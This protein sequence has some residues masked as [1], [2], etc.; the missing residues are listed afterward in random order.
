M[1]NRESHLSDGELVKAL[2]G[3]L[4]AKELQRVEAHLEAC[5]TCRARKG[6]MEHAIAD[7]VHLHETRTELRLPAADG[8]RA[9]LKARLA[10][11][12]RPERSGWWRVPPFQTRRW[13]VGTAC[14]LMLAF[15]GL[16]LFLTEWRTPS[17]VLAAP[18][19]ALTPGAA[20]L[21]NPNRLC[22]E[23]RPRNKD[24]STAVRRRV[25]EEYGLRHAASQA[26][27]VDY[28]ISPALGGAD[29]IHNL[30]P[31]PYTNTEW[32]AKVKDALEDRLRDLVCEGKVELATAQHDIATNWI[33]AYKKYF[34]TDRPVASEE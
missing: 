2:D 21:E 34:Q 33:E 5:W 18:N 20:I 15:L 19:P 31:Q 11:L 29:D 8:P 1:R 30:W 17:V 27:E 25:F 24:V 28:L 32:N 22:Q 4:R 13:I 10:E 7:F 6:A 26:Y 14:S 23:P 3:E 9:L 16:A 12:A